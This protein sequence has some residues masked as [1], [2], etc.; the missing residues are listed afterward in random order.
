MRG[1]AVG[2]A[3]P[4]RRSGT[5]PLRVLLATEAFLAAPA[6]GSCLGDLPETLVEVLPDVEFVVWNFG[7]GSQNARRGDLPANVVGVVDVVPPGAGSAT[8]GNRDDVERAFIPLFHELLGAITAT[9]F[10]PGQFARLLSALRTHFQVWDYRATWRSRAV[11]EAFRDRA[12]S[13]SNGF[14]ESA[15]ADGLV[16]LAW[17]F[18]GE[19]DGSLDDDL[20]SDGEIAVA[21]RFLSRSLWPVTAELPVTDLTH[22]TSG[23][24][25]A[26]PCLLAKVERKTPFVLT[27]ATIYLREQYLAL[28]RQGLPLPLKR[29][30]LRFSSALAQTAYHLADRVAPVCQW[31]GRW[32]RTYG[33]PASRIEVIYPGVDGERFR[34]MTLGRS[35]RPTVVSFASVSPAEDQ[36]TMLDVADRVRRTVPDVQFLHHGSVA[37]EPYW[38]RVRALSRERLL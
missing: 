32:E 8:A 2:G 9:D 24:L 36:E 35:P 34:P 12:A 4:D 17:T 26:I 38:E 18:P 14:G 37:D 20:P 6:T 22:A 7:A 27:E 11:R 29:L 1:Q 5:A 3:L 10:D 23:G 21:V 33:A 19:P 16:A 15:T 30:L 13:A 25:C 31:V 28:A